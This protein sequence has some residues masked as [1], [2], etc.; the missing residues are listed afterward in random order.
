MITKYLKQGRVTLHKKQSIDVHRKG[1]VL[2]HISQIRPSWSIGLP[3][4][5]ALRDLRVDGNG[6]SFVPTLYG[7]VSQLRDTVAFLS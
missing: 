7:D 5:P 4:C 2:S 1:I 3:D 6:L